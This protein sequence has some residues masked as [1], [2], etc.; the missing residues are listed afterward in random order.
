MLSI[1]GSNKIKV[2]ADVPVEEEMPPN[3]FLE[4]QSDEDE[5]DLSDLP[6]PPRFS[7]T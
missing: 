5:I 1:F 2:D 6:A 4:E 3:P 7:M